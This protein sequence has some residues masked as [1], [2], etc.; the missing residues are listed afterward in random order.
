MGLVAACASPQANGTLGL[1]FVVESADAAGFDRIEV[2]NEWA[3]ATTAQTREGEWAGIDS[4]L[5]S[6]TLVADGKPVQ[7]AHGPL[8]PG[9]YTHVFADAPRAT[10]FRADGAQVELV[11]HVEPI[12]RTFDLAPGEAVSVRIELVVMPRAQASGGGY[13]L[14]VKDAVIESRSLRPTRVGGLERDE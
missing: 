10:G 8:P 4:R 5:A 2:A 12:A 13:Q 3:G 1:S 9:S 7:V 14:F 11:S 6:L